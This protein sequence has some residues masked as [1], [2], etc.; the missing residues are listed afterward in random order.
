M[1]S[2]IPLFEQFDVPLVFYDQIGNGLSMHLPEKKGD[3]EFWTDDLF[4]AEL[5]NL[6][7]NWAW[8][9]QAII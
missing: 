6:L 8:M 1:L 5:T 7:R 9:N 4:H 3:E 2:F